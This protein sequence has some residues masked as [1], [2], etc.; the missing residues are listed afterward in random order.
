MGR[1][2]TPGPD[3]THETESDNV[4]ARAA[5]PEVVRG[6]ERNR[7]QSQGFTQ[8]GAEELVQ[9]QPL[10]MQSDQIRAN[11]SAGEIVPGFSSF[12]A[13]LDRTQANA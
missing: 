8:G 2:S 1:F 5:A 13:P 10:S 6:H 12:A 3:D 4:A 9:N 11:Q 7:L